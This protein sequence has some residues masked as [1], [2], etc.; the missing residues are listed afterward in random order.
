ATNDVHFADADMFEAHDA[1]LCVAQ[2]KRLGDPD[3]HRLTP[4]HR[5]KSAAEMRALFA[6]LPEAVDNTLVIAR[7]CAYMPRPHKP[8]LPAFGG[9]GG[10]SEAEELRAQAEEGLRQRLARHVVPAGA[11]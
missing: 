8:I 11:S 6:D 9:A 4:E 7:R 10:R 2:G 1:L 3:R 5:F